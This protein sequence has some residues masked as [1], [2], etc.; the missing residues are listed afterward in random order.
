MRRFV[1]YRTVLCT[2]ALLLPGFGSAVVPLT[3]AVL[4]I[5]L[6]VLAVTRTVIVSLA[7]WPTAK[8][9]TV[10]LTVP[11]VPTGGVVRLPT[12]ALRAA[13]RKTVPL[14]NASFP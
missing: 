7:L 14:G 13:L 3:L 2:V 5:V 12:F 4:V 8:S 10:H 1:A 6:P 9:A 11:A